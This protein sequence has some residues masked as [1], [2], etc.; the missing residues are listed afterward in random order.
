MILNAAVL[1]F[2]VV[3]PIIFLNSYRKFLKE[4]KAQVVEVPRKG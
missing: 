3:T 2:W 4:E 1:S